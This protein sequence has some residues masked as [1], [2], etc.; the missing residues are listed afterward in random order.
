MRC[1]NKFGAKLIF[2]LFFG[3]VSIKFTVEYVRK[4]TELNNSY[5]GVLS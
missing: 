2:F 4:Y 5:S 1:S 3:I